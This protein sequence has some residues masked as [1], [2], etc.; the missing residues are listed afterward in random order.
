MIPLQNENNHSVIYLHG[1]CMQSIDWHMWKP[2]LHHCKYCWEQKQ[3]ETALLLPP[4]IHWRI[5]AMCG[6]CWHDVKCQQKG[7]VMMFEEFDCCRDCA[8]KFWKN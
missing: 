2:A 6:N 3:S 1:E 8:D 7:G 4:G 5:C